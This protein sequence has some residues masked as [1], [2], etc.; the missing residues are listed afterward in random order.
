MKNDVIA[1]NLLDSQTTQKEESGWLIE[2]SGVMPGVNTKTVT[3]LYVKMTHKGYG[4]GEFAHTSDASKALR[5]ARKEDGEAILTMYRGLGNMP[6]LYTEPYSVTEHQWHNR[7]I[8]VPDVTTQPH[9]SV[10][11]PD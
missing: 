3:W 7:C 2:H 1:E 11:Q 10:S 6:D 8:E 4:L 5:F 9:H